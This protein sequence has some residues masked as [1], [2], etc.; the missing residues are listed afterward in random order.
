MNSP[1]SSVIMLTLWIWQDGGG[2]H[3]HCIIYTRGLKSQLMR[4]LREMCKVVPQHNYKNCSQGFPKRRQPSPKSDSCSALKIKLNK[5]KSQQIRPDMDLL[6][7]N[8]CEVKCQGLR[9]SEHHSWGKLH[10]TPQ[11]QETANFYGAIQACA[12]W[13]THTVRQENWRRKL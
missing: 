13:Q 11:S 3:N 12:P 2:L 8:S 4:A 7:L 1:H 6:R 10:I 9:R 5:S